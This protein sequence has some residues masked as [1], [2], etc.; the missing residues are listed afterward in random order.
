MLAEH[1][2]STATLLEAPTQGLNSARSTRRFPN[3]VWKY[4]REHEWAFAVVH[5]AIVEI[6]TV[7]AKL[8]VITFRADRDRVSYTEV[9][10]DAGIKISV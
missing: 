7:K 5:P 2:T 6:G 3:A 10:Q 9:R 8:Q 4:M 1:P